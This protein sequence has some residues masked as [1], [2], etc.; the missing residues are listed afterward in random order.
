[1]AAAGG[2][3]LNRLLLGD[4]AGSFID[5]GLF[6]FTASVALGTGLAI[7]LAPVLQSVRGNQ[8]SDLRAGGASGGR[9]AWGTRMTLLTTQSALCMTM[10]IGA[11]L[12]ALSLKRVAGLDLGIDA[13]HTIQAT[14]NLDELAVP[15][16]VIQTTYDEMLLRV[17]SIPVV[18]EAAVA[19]RDPYAAGRA[20]SPRTLTRGSEH[21]WPPVHMAFEAGVGD[22]FFRA[23]GAASLRGRDFARTDDRGAPPVAIV[24]APFAK[25]YFPKEDALG[26][27]IIL[28]ARASDDS[29]ICVTVVGVLSGVWFGTI[30]NRD[31]PM[32]YVPLAQKRGY[33]GTF[34]PRG[35]FVR[36]KGEPGLAVEQVRRALQSVRSDLP[37]VT[38]KVFRDVVEAEMRPWRLGTTMFTV[39]GGVALVV[40]VVGLY[41]VVAFAAEQRSYEIAVRQALGARRRDVLRT[42]S[43]DALGAVT[44]GLAIGTVIILVVGRW[45]GPLLYQTDASD[46]GVILGVA[47]LLF[48]V[49]FLAALVPTARAVRSNTAATLRTS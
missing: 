41:A 16:P 35:I 22:G 2:P 12:F 23:V 49:G 39:F 37:A 11:G 25:T 10:L 15:D 32:V 24:N 14:V 20:V 34:R 36:V 30:F 46:P 42:V 43:G 33:D 26:Q 45:V 21:F 1:V 40:A 3:L 19:S 44:L 47:A 18:V 6:M 29:N 13:Q 9:R 7:S 4:A 31:K 5:T 8:I 28:P 27:C 17:R 48:A 38:V